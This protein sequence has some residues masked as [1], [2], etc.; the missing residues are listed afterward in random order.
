MTNN[1]IDLD[2]DEDDIESV[3]LDINTVKEELPTYTSEKLC[4]MI[5]CD[6]YFGCY[7]DIAIMCMEELAARR[8]AGDQYDF[9]THIDKS[10]A[11]MPKLDFVMPDL[12]EV[13]RKLAGKSFL[14]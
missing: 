7:K 9:E 14:K 3:P 6:R 4:E 13:L 1:F 5:V 10:L 12:G 8:A 2:D 11:D